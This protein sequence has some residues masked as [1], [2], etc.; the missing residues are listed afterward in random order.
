MELRWKRNFRSHVL[1][2]GWPFTMGA[3]NSHPRAAFSA[4][5]EKYRLGPAEANFAPVTVPDASTSTRTITLMVPEIVFL[6]LLETSGT[7][8]R[9]T[10]PEEEAFWAGGAAS[11]AGATL[12]GG[13]VGTG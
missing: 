9:L 6:A 13:A 8:L 10:P 4:R 11:G 2:V 5:L 12:A 7:T 3:E 1:A